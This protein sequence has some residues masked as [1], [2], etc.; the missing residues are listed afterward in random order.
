[1]ITLLYFISSLKI[2][3]SFSSPINYTVAMKYNLAIFDMD[4]TILSTLDDLCDSTNVILKRHGWPLHTVEEIR[5]MVGN[6]LKKLMERACP[7]GTDDETISKILAEFIEYYNKH[8]ADKTRPYDGIPELLKALREKGVTVA[9]NT[10]KIQSAAEELCDLYFK[11]LF[12]IIAGNTPDIPVKPAPDGVHKIMKNFAAEK[13]LQAADVHAVYIG[14]SDVDYMTGKNSG[15]DFI[16]CDWGFRGEEFLRKQ[17]ASVIAK[18]PA[19]V[20]KLM[21]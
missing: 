16:G 19:D 20:I 13:G 18:K 9:V 2:A 7:A 15:I 4:G 6:G 1:M 12:D 14:D 5:F 17:G 11:D 3:L 8:C 21:S 10:N